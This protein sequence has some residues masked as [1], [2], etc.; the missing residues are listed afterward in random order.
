MFKVLPYLST[1]LLLLF[2]LTQGQPVVAQTMPETEIYL[3]RVKNKKGQWK[4]S[5]PQNITRRPGYDNQPAFTPNGKNILFTSIRE[6][7]STDIYSYEIKKNQLFQ[8]TNSPEGEYSPTIT[9]DKKGISVVRGE[10]QQIWRLPLTGDSEPVPVF[11]NAGKVGYYAWLSPENLAVFIL[12][13]PHT[14]HLATTAGDLSEPLAANIGRGLQKI[15]GQE[16][17]SFISKENGDAW[18]I[19]QLDLR[20]RQITTLVKTLP[21][22]EDFIWTKD[23]RILM[24]QG[25]KLYQYHPQHSIDWT[26]IADFS[27]IGIKNITRL[28][29]D[30]KGK[31][32]AF[33][34]VM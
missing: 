30:A 14:L 6:R 18:E 20:T 4:I 25:P 27:A 21:A 32:L 3:C 16:A 31:Q 22:S 2:C 34:G 12:G 19:K 26:E 8:L 13:D 9:P 1:L 10:E 17:V 5:Q 33:V 7:P 11:R 15:P 29:L 24:A 23:G 28:A